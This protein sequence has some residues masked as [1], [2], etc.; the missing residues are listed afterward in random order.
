[1]LGQQRLRVSAL[2][3]H[4]SP[5]ENALSKIKAILKKASDPTIGCRWNAIGRIIDNISPSV[6]QTGFIALRYGPV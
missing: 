1:V 3:F 5:I 6:T 4:F 2:Q